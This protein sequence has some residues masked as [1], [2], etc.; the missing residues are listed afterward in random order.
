MDDDPDLD[1]AMKVCGDMNYVDA[2]NKCMKKRK[3]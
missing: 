3:H 2:T 1:R